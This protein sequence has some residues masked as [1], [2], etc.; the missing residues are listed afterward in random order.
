MILILYLAD[1]TLSKNLL[2]QAA[3]RT[4]SRPA[5]RVGG[6]SLNS[7]NY[8][9]DPS[10]SI[11]IPERGQNLPIPGNITLGPAFWD[12][13]NAFPNAQYIVGTYFKACRPWITT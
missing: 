1:F 7:A 6:N 13:F 4:N 12:C 8:V 9:S 10:T 2:A 3:A 11:I 5:I